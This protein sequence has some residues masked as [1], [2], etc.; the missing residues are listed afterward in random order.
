MVTSIMLGA[1]DTLPV[2]SDTWL[3][4][5]LGSQTDS[6]LAYYAVVRTQSAA[7]LDAERDKATQ[8]LAQYGTNPYRVRL[9]LLLMAP[10]SRF[11]SDVAAIALLNDVLKDGYAESTSMRNFASFLLIKLNEQQR[12]VD[13]QIQRVRNEQKRSEELAQKLRDEQKRSDDLQIK[14]DAIK[15]M[16]K[17]LM[18][19]DK[20]L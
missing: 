5:K 11:H 8:Q 2:G 4:G 6:L 7:E 17:S 14:V 3:P 12:L 13:E 16:E 10:N 15:N 20:H 18:H 9:A 1:C 19:R